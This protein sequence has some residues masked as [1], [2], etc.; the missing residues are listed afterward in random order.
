MDQDYPADHGWCCNVS[1]SL[2]GQENEADEVNSKKPFIHCHWLLG[3]SLI[4]L[5]SLE[6]PQSRTQMKFLEYTDTSIRS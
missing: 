1:C 2:S 3:K 4:I 6:G 5:M